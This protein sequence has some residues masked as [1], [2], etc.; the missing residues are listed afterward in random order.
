ML[1]LS[2][3]FYNGWVNALANTF[4]LPKINN[5]EYLI[6]RQVSGTWVADA[7]QAAWQPSATPSTANLYSI[8]GDMWKYKTKRS[9]YKYKARY[10]LQSGDW[11]ELVFEQL[12][13]PFTCVA[14]G[15]PHKLIS[16]QLDIGAT[17]GNFV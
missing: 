5:G 16:S 17:L 3:R 8:M 11:K 1:W 9:T 4:V 2:D 13:T 7:F 15:M 14:E 10:K 6:Y 12:F